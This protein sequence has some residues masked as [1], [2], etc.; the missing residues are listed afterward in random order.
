MQHSTEQLYGRA[1]PT[2][3][4]GDDRV[5]HCGVRH[6][7]TD[8]K[9]Q[10]GA[11]ADCGATPVR[12][13]RSPRPR[14]LC[15]APGSRSLQSTRLQTDVLFAHS[16]TLTNIYNICLHNASCDLAENRDEQLLNNVSIMKNHIVHLNR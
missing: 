13:A 9:P 6:T 3:N 7:A 16:L 14:T 5:L 10:A 15:V 8:N 12:T 2:I 1:R 4:K 11:R